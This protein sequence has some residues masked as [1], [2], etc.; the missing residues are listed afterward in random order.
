MMQTLIQFQEGLYDITGVN[1]GVL[2]LIQLLTSP[3]KIPN[4]LTH[5][6]SSVIKELQ[7]CLE[8]AEDNKNDKQLSY[9]DAEDS[10][11]AT[12]L[13]DKIPSAFQIECPVCLQILKRPFQVQCCGKNICSNC[14]K[15]I[16]EE[17]CACPCCKQEKFEGFDNKGLEQSLHK[18]RFFCKYKGKCCKWTGGLIERKRHILECEKRR[19]MCNFCK[20]FIS[21]Y[22]DVTR[23]HWPVCGCHPLQC[24]NGCGSCLQRKA[25]ENH[26][27]HICPK[28]VIN[29]EFKLFGCKEQLQRKDMGSHVCQNVAMHTSLQFQTLNE[30]YL[31]LQADNQHMKIVLKWLVDS[32]GQTLHLP[33]GIKHSIAS[34][35]TSPSLDSEVLSEIMKSGVSLSQHK[36]EQVV[37]WT[38]TNLEGEGIFL[39]IPQNA[40]DPSDTVTVILQACS[41]GLFELPDDLE[42]VSPVFLM[43]LHYPFRSELTL[44]IRHFACIQKSS[45]IE[46]FIFVSTSLPKLQPDVSNSSTWKLSPYAQPSFS[47]DYSRGK[48]DINGYLS[49][50]GALARK[51]KQGM[52]N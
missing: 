33:L 48:V 1:Y 39:I 8:L 18:L 20:N 42:F 29:C 16:Q 7:V 23:N 52:Y 5:I 25:M 21:E 12:D 13:V 28:S 26:I 44:I 38:G 30:E 9:S 24:P 31:K 36:A 14:I 17:N 6:K 19:F 15:R 3:S 41:S 11:F 47:S 43:I 46:D 34:L 50:F 27:V 10:V 32:L 4:S 22:D 37:N 40:V 35:T 45:D 51:R 49:C 2:K